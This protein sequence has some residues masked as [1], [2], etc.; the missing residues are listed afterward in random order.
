MDPFDL[1]LCILCIQ[2]SDA[3]TASYVKKLQRSAKGSMIPV[4]V[5]TINLAEV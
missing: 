1:S 2:H 5:P 3:H 4:P